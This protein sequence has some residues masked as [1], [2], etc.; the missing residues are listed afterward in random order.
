M[1]KVHDGSAYVFAMVDGSQGP[2]ERTL[3]LPRGVDGTTAEVL[4]E[5][6]SLPVA[7]GVVADT[8]AEEYTW[9]VY[10]VPLSGDQP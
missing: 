4:F 7:D 1:L 8:F 9:H 5:D 6:R 3:R 2:G 10:R